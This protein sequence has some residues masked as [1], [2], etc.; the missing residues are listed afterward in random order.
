MGTELLETC[1]GSNKR[2]IEEI[3]RQV[4]HLPDLGK[5]YLHTKKTQTKAYIRNRV[6]NATV[7]LVGM[8]LTQYSS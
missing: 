6:T 2:S 1:R 3:V 8:L 5:E 4:G 7:M